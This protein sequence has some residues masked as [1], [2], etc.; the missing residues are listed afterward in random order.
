MPHAADPGAAP[1]LLSAA[2]PLVSMPEIAALAKVRRPVVST[3]RRRYANFPP[4]VED[5]SGRPLFDGRQVADWLITTGLGNTDPAQLRSEVALFGIAAQ[6]SR[7]SPWQLTQI[8]GSLLCLRHLDGVP[9]TA[10]GAQDDHQLWATLVRRAERMDAEDELLLRELR[11]ADATAAPLAHRAEALVEAA[12][13]ERGAYEWLLASRSRLGL[14]ALTA[15][16]E[17]PELQLLLAQLADLPTRL[18]RGGSDKGGG[19]R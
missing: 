14:D 2:A 12:Y 11:S 4:A 1:S 10:D 5:S 15:D 18:R 6:R 17:A 7:F 9:L 8:A 13:D 19:A 3:W 16:A